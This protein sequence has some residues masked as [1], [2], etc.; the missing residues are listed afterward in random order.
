MAESGKDPVD[1]REFL[2]GAAAGAAGLVPTPHGKPVALRH[3]D[4]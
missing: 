2:K 1:R 3:N 4:A